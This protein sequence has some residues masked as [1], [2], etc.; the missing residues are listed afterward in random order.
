MPDFDL[1]IDSYHTPD[2]LKQ[3]L[4]Q[5]V[6][7]QGYIPRINSPYA[8]AITPLKHYRQNK[9]VISVM[10]EANRKIYMDEKTMQK[11]GSFDLICD[12]CSKLMRKAADLVWEQYNR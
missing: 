5:E 10:F 8:G 7:D 12:V 2:Y 11:N 3:G 6:I 4:W 1:G 9:D